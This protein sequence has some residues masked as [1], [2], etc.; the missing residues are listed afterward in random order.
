MPQL[1]TVNLIRGR[2]PHFIDFFIGWAL[3]VGR[4]LV[5]LT[6]VVALGAFL[7]RFGL[8]KQIVDL[9]DRIIQEQNIIKFAKKNEDTYRN[10]QTRLD[11]AN[12]IIFNQ[13]Q[14][15]KTYKDITSL[16][17]AQ[18][19]VRSV[20]FADDSVKIDASIQS[21]S[22]LATTINNI[23][24]YPSVDSVSLDTIENKTTNGVISIGLTIQFKK[25]LIKQI[26]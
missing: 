8:D 1:V 20:T 19:D 24:N 13:N 16:I 10:L 17:P 18:M 12:T 9:H 3:T 11:L 4:A 15:F 14:I 23:K 22:L 25:G 2:K 26:Q 7:Y 5:I 6:E 21:I